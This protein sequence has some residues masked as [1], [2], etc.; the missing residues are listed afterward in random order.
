[1]KGVQ[2]WQPLGEIFAFHYKVG[3]RPV[4]NHQTEPPATR[5]SDKKGFSGISQC[6]MVY[7]VR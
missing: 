2:K 5:I 7:G 6:D 1:M 3:Q 4:G